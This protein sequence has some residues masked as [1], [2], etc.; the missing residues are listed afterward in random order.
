M[1]D[2][3][4]LAMVVGGV[5][6][7]GANLSAALAT[8]ERQRQGRLERLDWVSNLAQMV[9]HVE[10]EAWCGARD[11]AMQWVPAALK[12]PIFDAAVRASLAG[13]RFD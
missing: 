7:H 11:T 5:A 3:E 9:G 6:Q 13:R 2:A 4:H 12:S 8:Y 1:E 10:S